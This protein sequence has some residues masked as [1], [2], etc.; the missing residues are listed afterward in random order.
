MPAKKIRTVY[1][2]TVQPE[3]RVGIHR[4]DLLGMWA[5]DRMTYPPVLIEPT[6]T[7]AQDVVGLRGVGQYVASISVGALGTISLMGVRSDDLTYCRCEKVIWAIDPEA[8]VAKIASGDRVDPGEINVPLSKKLM[9]VC[10]R[11][12]LMAEPMSLVVDDLY[13]SNDPLIRAAIADVRQR[14]FYLNKCPSECP[15]DGFIVER[16]DINWPSNDD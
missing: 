5:M 4:A 7:T 8:V 13:P 1:T 15:E 16:W 14:W 6:I 2:K 9:S 11:Q 12:K 10:L 3:R